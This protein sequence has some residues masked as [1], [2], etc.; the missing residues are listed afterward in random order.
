MVQFGKG[1][2]NSTMNRMNYKKKDKV[3]SPDPKAKETSLITRVWKGV[4]IRAFCTEK[5]S[6]SK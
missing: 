5:I 1:K 6:K 4:G 2:S 3:K